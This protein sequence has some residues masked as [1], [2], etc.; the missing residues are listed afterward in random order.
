[1]ASGATVSAAALAGCI[2]SENND[3]SNTTDGSTGKYKYGREKPEDSAA[4]GDS[5]LLFTQSATRAEDFDPIVA[6]DSPSVQVLNRVFD[7]LYEW[8]GGLG[9]EPKIATSMPDIERDGTR[10]L[11]EIEQGVTFHNGNELTAS[12]VAHSFTA[13]VEEKTDNA[14]QYNM[15]SSAEPIDDY[16]LQ[17]DLKFPYG[18]FTVSTIGINIVPKNTRTNDRKAFNENPVGSGPFRFSEFE[19][20]EYVVLKRWEDYWDDPKPHVG[21][22]RFEAAPDNANR[23][24]QIRGE[25]TSIIDGVPAQSWDTVESEDGVRLHRSNSPSF[26]YI[27]FNCNEGLTTDPDVRRGVAHC[28]SLSEYVKEYLGPVA[29]SLASPI[30]KVTSQQW[31]FPADE[32]EKDMPGYDPDK[33]QSLLEDAGVPDDWTPKIIAPQGGPRAALAERIGTR[34]TEI[35]YSADVQTMAFAQLIQTATTGKAADYQLYIAGYTG[36]P[37]PD[38]VMYNVFHKSQAGI[39]HGHF[40]PGQENFHEKIIEA[41][42]T[43]D[44]NERNSLYIDI[45]EEIIEYLPVLSAYSEHNTMAALDTVKDFHAHPNVATN[46]R[47]VSDYGNVWVDN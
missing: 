30:P 32:W 12:D 26:N 7:R 29:A 35:G 34:L 42:R 5:T 46:P 14:G 27:A 38:T 21:Q 2:G 44:Q 41:R 19:P 20:G 15:I 6:Y 39:G 10:Y 47:V 1:M 23:V 31:D 17:V 40:Y 45:I 9:L 8:D 43:A 18:P 3:D 16:Q 28:F 4:V 11:F 13:P 33:A 36:G 37:D 22:I 24:A 25:D